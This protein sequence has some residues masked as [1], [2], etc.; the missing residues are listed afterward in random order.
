MRPFVPQT[1]PYTPPYTPMSTSHRRLPHLDTPAIERG[2]FA[3]PLRRSSSA[4]SN[5]LSAPVGALSEVNE[6]EKFLRAASGR[7]VPTFRN[8]GF[9]PTS[10][11]SYDPL[12]PLTPLTRLSPMTPLA[13]S[14]RRSL[15]PSGSPLVSRPE[16]PP[17]VSPT[18]RKAATR[19]EL[20]D[21][22]RK[23][24]LSE[25][26]IW[27]DTMRTTLPQGRSLAAPGLRANAPPHLT[28]LEGNRGFAKWWGTEAIYKQ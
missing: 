15:P 11:N 28:Y 23:Q 2:T 8:P 22:R 4:L 27:F 10:S 19:S 25:N 14:M 20:L 3:T 7:A 17:F 6:R 18:H 12:T 13:S 5:S 1:P 21:L 26:A 9:S 16:L 24:S